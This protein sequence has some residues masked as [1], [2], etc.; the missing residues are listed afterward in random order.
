MVKGFLVVF[1]RGKKTAFALLITIFAQSAYAQMCGEFLKINPPLVE[2][3][4]ATVAIK[5]IYKDNMNI[6]KGMSH[7]TSGVKGVSHDGLI[8]VRYVN[9]ELESRAS[10]LLEIGKT[11]KDEFFSGKLVEEDGEIILLVARKWEKA[12]FE[13]DP[14]S[15]TVVNMSDFS[16]RE[17]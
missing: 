17:E 3:R 8:G 5:D 14:E 13:F 9:A 15:P 7:Y 1:L 2:G 6:F 12:G 10:Y 11:Q 16:N 4:L